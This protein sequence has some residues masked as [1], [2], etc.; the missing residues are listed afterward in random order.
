MPG[1]VYCRAVPSLFTRP[2]VCT[3]DRSVGGVGGGVGSPEQAVPFSANV[4]GSG[5]AV[6]GRLARNPTVAL[7]LVASVPFQ[8]AFRAVTWVVFWVTVAPQAWVICWPPGN[9]QVSVQLVSG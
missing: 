6:P 2:T 5:L 1:Q 8:G 7:A 9:D 3:L 4:A